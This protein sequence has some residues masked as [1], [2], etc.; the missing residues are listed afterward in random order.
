[1][2]VCMS[3][4]ACIV[5]V[6]LCVYERVCVCDNNIVEGTTTVPASCTVYIP[7]VPSCVYAHR[8]GRRATT[9]KSPYWSQ[10]TYTRIYMQRTSRRTRKLTSGTRY[11]FTLNFTRSEHD[12]HRAAATRVPVDV[13]MKYKSSPREHTFR[14]AITRNN[15]HIIIDI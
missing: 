1:M 14:H 9:P 5:F 8:I 6:C 3:A 13:Q 10:P 2:C 15:N 4:C 7:T 11:V 12:V